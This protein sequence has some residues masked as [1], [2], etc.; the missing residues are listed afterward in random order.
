MRKT[1]PFSSV[2]P[3]SRNASSASPVLSAGKPWLVHTTHA[4]APG[5]AERRFWEISSILAI[6]RPSL[7]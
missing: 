4:V 1:V 6:A 5:R 7:S 3:V 2:V